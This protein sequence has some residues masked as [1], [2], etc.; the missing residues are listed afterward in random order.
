M[1]VY[2]KRSPLITA[3]PWTIATFL[4]L[5]IYVTTGYGRLSSFFFFFLLFLA[6]LCSVEKTAGRRVVG[7]WFV[8]VRDA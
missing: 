4:Q 8:G 5:G 2:K 3:A 1:S 6:V 7:P